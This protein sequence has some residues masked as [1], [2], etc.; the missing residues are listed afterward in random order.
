[1]CSFEWLDLA[2]PGR[3][4]HNFLAQPITLLFTK[5]SYDDSSERAEQSSQPWR[6]QH[7]GIPGEFE[8]RED[9]DSYFARVQL[10][11][12]ANKV[13]EEEKTD[14]FYFTNS[15]SQIIIHPKNMQF[16]ER[17]AFSLLS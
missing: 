17:L 6:G 1:M 11:W 9:L 2:R 10:F 7:I 3:E 14:P 5:I 8:E 4:K 16:M 13:A 12:R 15:I